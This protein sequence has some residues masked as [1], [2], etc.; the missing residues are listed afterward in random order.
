MQKRWGYRVY[1]NP[2]KGRHTL[3]VGAAG[4]HTDVVASRCLPQKEWHVR[5]GLLLWCLHVPKPTQI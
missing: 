5:T 2:H 3:R 4:Q 1:L